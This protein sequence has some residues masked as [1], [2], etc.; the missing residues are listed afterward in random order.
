MTPPRQGLPRAC[1]LV[2]PADFARVYAGRRSAAA[3]PLVVYAAASDAA[4]K[5]R[6]GFS[7]S[8]RIGTAVVRN[9]WKRRL[10]EAFRIARSELPT[11]HDFVVVVRS[12][13][14]EPGAAG[15]QRTATSLARLAARAAQAADDRRP[16]GG[17]GRRS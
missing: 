3:G 16:R 6:M 9:R 10:R 14:P 4:G 15:L 1:R 11:G 13:L 12:G 5:V 17:Q 7:V 8:R 2:R